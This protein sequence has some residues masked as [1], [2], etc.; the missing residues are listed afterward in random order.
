MAW[1]PPGVAVEISTPAQLT[2]VAVDCIQAIDTI[3]VGVMHLEDGV[4]AIR[5]HAAQLSHLSY[6]LR[7]A[8]AKGEGGEE[9]GPGPS[10]PPPGVAP[11]SSWGVTGQGGDRHG[12]PGAAPGGPG[13]QE[14]G[15][16][17]AGKAAHGENVRRIGPIAQAR[18]RPAWT[19]PLRAVRWRTS[20]HRTRG[21]AE[22]AGSYERP[23]KRRK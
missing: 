22:S 18:A 10:R 6:R 15:M 3:N 23:T 13:P 2:R 17:Q 21:A 20:S 16:V 9:H 8:I 19:G 1:R 11:L 14:M 4:Q 5:N 12:F 7:Q